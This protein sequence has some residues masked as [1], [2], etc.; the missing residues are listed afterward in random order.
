[1][2]LGSIRPTDG[3][4]QGRGMGRS[5]RLSGRIQERGPN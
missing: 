4:L 3:I 2:T 5:M 1:M